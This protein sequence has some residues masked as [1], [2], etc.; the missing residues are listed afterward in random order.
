MKG[1]LLSQS[2]AYVALTPSRFD[3]ASGFGDPCDTMRTGLV[4]LSIFV[5][6]A[7]T[8]VPQDVAYGPYGPQ[9]GYSELMRT[10]R[11]FAVR[12]TG[13]ARMAGSTVRDLAL[14]R[15]AEVTLASGNSWF[16]IEEEV[17]ESGHDLLNTTMS[18]VRQTQVRDQS[19][20]TVTR[21]ESSAQ[22]S[23]TE[24][25]SQYLYEIR[26]FREKPELSAAKD[27]AAVVADMK[28]KYGL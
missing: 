22:F 8:T 16:V 6:G 12:Y 25:I 10:D 17:N 26:C 14:L 9:G 2:I 23:E 15:C 18:G 11:T 21:T 19:N 28:T 5:L 13:H 3:T 7:C 27:A 1:R 24:F 20:R 4:L